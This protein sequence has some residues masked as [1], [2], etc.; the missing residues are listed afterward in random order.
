MFVLTSYAVAVQVLHRRLGDFVPFSC[1]TS[2]ASAQRFGSVA[3]SRKFSPLEYPENGRKGFLHITLNVGGTP[4]HFINVHLAADLDNRT[5]VSAS[6][7]PYAVQRKQ[8]LEVVLR[9][10]SVGG[11]TAAAYL[12]GGDFNF[13]L[14][15]EK[16]WQEVATSPSDAVEAKSIRCE[17]VSRNTSDTHLL[18][19]DLESKSFLPRLQEQPITF[20]PTYCLK[21]DD[22]T[23]DSK[24]L[25]CWPDR[26]LYSPHLIQ[27]SNGKMRYGAH[28]WGA[29]HAFV[30]LSFSTMPQTG[31]TPTAAPP[32]S[33]I[34]G[35]GPPRRDSPGV[36]RELV[37]LTLV[38]IATLAVGY[39][40]YS[41]FRRK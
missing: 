15:C 19:W 27:I 10:C 25:P 35:G 11:D 5:S 9:E 22:K 20:G 41:T 32:K 30:S 29:D 17:Y 33:R 3:H 34:A 13:R 23:Y 31:A 2:E 18:R 8:L 16:L 24:R 40:V 36:L 37:P 38:T 4:L 39:L 28:R 1:L 26:V 21:E 7:S 12:V 6:P 14:D